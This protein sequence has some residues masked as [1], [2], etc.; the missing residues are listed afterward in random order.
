MTDDLDGYVLIGVPRRSIFVE[1]GVALHG[2]F[3]HNNF[4]WSMS[5]GCVNLRNE[6]AKWLSRWTVPLSEPADWEKTGCGTQGI[7]YGWVSQTD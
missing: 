5:P 4:S 1:T 7:V 2:T 6:D 3:R